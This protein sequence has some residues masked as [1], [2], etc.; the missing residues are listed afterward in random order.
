MNM[1]KGEMTSTQLITLIIIIVSFA[2]ILLVWYSFS[3]NPQIDKEVCHTSIVLR[4][5]ANNAI[6]ETSKVIPLKC[7][8]EKICLTCGEDCEQFKADTKVKVSS[9]SE[10][11]KEEILDT[12]ANAMYDCNS[13]LG[14]GK[15]DFM[16]HKTWS[17]NYCLICSRFAL[18]EKA[19]KEVDGIG[20][21]ELYKYL[22]EKK[23]PNGK[24]YLEYL[25]PG[26]KNWEDSKMLFENMKE[27]SDNEEFRRLSFE[28]WNIN[29]NSYDNGYSIVAQMRPTGT[30]SKWLKIGGVLGGG[31]V[32]VVGIA[33]IPV[34]GPIGAAIAAVGTKVA[35]GS[36]LVT[37]GVLYV[38]DHPSNKYKWVPPSILPYDLE[39][40]K[41]LKCTS[42]ETAP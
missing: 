34:S 20:Y 3:W 21:G 36:A 27:E 25:Y 2:I 10:K 41:A 39:T 32:A 5:S 24:S 23:T 26:W 18:D 40:F 8:T 42:F 37:G 9:D 17:E 29:L 35:V 30:W 6:F 13:M 11:A 1:K 12:I 4:S 33:L 22:G 38:Y 19:K 15:L 14:E 16:P 7:K 31:I 28:E